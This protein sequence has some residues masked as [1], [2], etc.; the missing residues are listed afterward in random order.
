MLREAKRKKNKKKMEDVS[1]EGKGKDKMNE[2]EEEGS[3]DKHKVKL[4]EDIAE[5]SEVMESLV[6]LVNGG[7]SVTVQ[8]GVMILLKDLITQCN[9]EKKDK[10]K[11][12]LK[13]FGIV[14]ILNNLVSVGV[15]SV[16][17][18]IAGSK[19]S[20]DHQVMFTRV[21]TALLEELT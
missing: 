8:I 17:L 3:K 9:N 15:G 10:L 7:K 11:G 1:V 2:E 6:R 19:N 12:I 18:S 13:E 16:G 14:D 5:R 21:R 4:E 20:D